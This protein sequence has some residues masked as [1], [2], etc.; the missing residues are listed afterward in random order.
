V[1]T[2]SVAFILRCAECEAAWLTGDD[3]HWRAYLG[4]DTLDE[5]REVVSYCTA[6]AEREFGT[7]PGDQGAGQR[8]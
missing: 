3:E 7:D 6:C 1:S 2:E 8:G 4:S 5:V